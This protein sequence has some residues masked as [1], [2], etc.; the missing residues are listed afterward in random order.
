MTIATKK[1]NFAKLAMYILKKPYMIKKLLIQLKKYGLKET[2]KKIKS[3]FIQI[4]A[5]PKCTFKKRKK[6]YDI[7][8]SVIIPTYNRSTLLPRLINSWRVV[9]TVTKYKYEIIFSDD[10][11]NDGTQ[12]ILMQVKDLPIIV[13]KNIH[14]G[15]AK[16]RNHAILQAKGE[17]LLIIGDDIFP[18]PQ[19]IN[20]H[21]EKLKELP[22]C[23]AVLGE[24]TWHHDLKINT[25][26]KHITEI[27]CEQFSFKSFPPHGYIDFRHFYTSNISIDREFLLTEKTIF[28]ESF[29]KYNFE[30]IELGLRLFKKGMDIYYLKEAY[31]E[32]Y[33]PYNSVQSFCLRQK[34]AGEM[35]LVFK[36]LHG[37]EIEWVLQTDKILNQWK[38]YINY[39]NMNMYKDKPNFLPQ[40][41]DL[42]QKL[43][44]E[45]LIQRFN[46]ENLTSNIYL[47]LFRFFYEMGI[48]EKSYQLDIEKIETVFAIYFVPQIEEHLEKIMEITNLT[49]L[50]LS[51]NIMTKLIIEIDNSTMIEVT[52]EKYKGLKDDIIIQIGDNTERLGKNYIY[53]PKNNFLLSEINLRQVILFINNNPSSDIILL[54]FGLVDIP[55]IGISSHLEN[56]LIFR[57]PKNTIKDLKSSILSGK[58]IRLISENFVTKISF[59]NLI[60][61]PLGEY[62]HW[63]KK[64]I[65]Y[66]EDSGVLYR[67]TPYKKT[68]KIIFVFPIFLAVGGVERNTA[69]VIEV[70]KNQYDFVVVTFEKLDE[71][72]GALHHQFIKNCLGIYDLTELS[73]H[74]GILNYLMVLNQFYKPE[75]IWLCNGS[76]WLEQNLSQIRSTFKK[77]AIVDQQVYDTNEG[78]VRLYKEKN[79]ALLSFDRFIAINSKIKDVFIAKVNIKNDKIDLI[80]PAVKS[81]KFTRNFHINNKLDYIKKFSVDLTKKNFI[82]VGRMNAQKRPFLFLDVVKIIS[83]SINNIHF[84]MVGTGPLSND[85]EKYIF[86]HKLTNFI[87]RVTHIENVAEIYTLMD[88]LIITSKFEGLPIAMLEAM[89]M[90]L[91]V[92]STNVGD[93][94]VVINEYKNGMLVDMKLKPKALAKHFIEF[95]EQ[96][97]TYSEI[98][99]KVSELIRDRFSVDAVSNNYNSCFEQAMKDALEKKYL[100]NTKVIHHD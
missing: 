7:K 75:L 90:G 36:K 41:I 21:Y 6:D 22:I 72:L 70:L 10:G 24:V 63:N 18:N 56:N 66:T 62:G 80:Y 51:F 83:K 99:L 5:R 34:I 97:A 53:R 82:F 46:L 95:Y 76:H 38:T 47:V 73:S 65:G 30:D 88:G 42:C 1:Y 52:K 31:G 25:L 50:D 11:S 74:D 49:S 55:N 77:S 69:E 57:N 60:N 86:E 98:S 20:Q 67:P 93:I 81:E 68:K 8:V 43:E 91:P 94:D 23:K 3:T 54:S 78:W 45:N 37:D 44:D 48:I 58:V 29:Y 39:I 71:P 64:S 40:I 4:S 100:K 35:A 14:G 17:K 92:F 32:H 12:D 19:I 59:E 26:M 96:L 89:C 85:V 61:Q 15:A 28:D 79:S 13:L 27:G 16:A 84:Y 9:D 87:T 2:L 33:H